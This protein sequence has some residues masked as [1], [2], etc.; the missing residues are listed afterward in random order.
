MIRVIAI[1]VIPG[2]RRPNTAMAWLLAIFLV[3][4]IALPVFFVFGNNRLSRRRQRLQ[5]QIN[6]ELFSSS[7]CPRLPQ[8]SLIWIS[9]NMVSSAG[10]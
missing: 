3:P 2:G 1:G 4:L 6:E 8:P 5:R 9:E 7:R 10:A